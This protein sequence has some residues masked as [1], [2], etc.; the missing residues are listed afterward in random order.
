MAFPRQG[1]RRGAYHGRSTRGDGGVDRGPWRYGPKGRRNGGRQVGATAGRPRGPRAATLRPEG[2]RRF[3]SRCNRGDDL[4]AAAG[5]AYR[6]TTARRVDATVTHE[7]MQSR[8]E[9]RGGGAAARW[10]DAA[11]NRCS[12]GGE[13]RG[14]R[15]DLH[16]TCG[17]ARNRQARSAARRR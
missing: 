2:Q 13:A 9:P 6:G 3:A 12:I 5:T 7:S 17:G 4:G 16:G 11:A 8:G 14:T 1:R 10:G 15:D